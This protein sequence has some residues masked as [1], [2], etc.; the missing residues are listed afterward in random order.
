[1]SRRSFSTRSLSELQPD[2]PIINLADSTIVLQF[3]DCI[4]N[5]SISCR[6]SIWSQ[7]VSFH[8]SIQPQTRLHQHVDDILLYLVIIYGKE[9][10]PD[11]DDVV[12]ISK[13]KTFVASVPMIRLKQYLQHK[14]FPL[15]EHEFVDNNDYFARMIEDY[16]RSQLMYRGDISSVAS[17]TS[18]LPSL[19][20]I[21]GMSPDA[22]ALYTK[23]EDKMMDLFAS[24]FGELESRINHIEKEVYSIK[25]TLKNERTPTT[26]TRDISATVPDH[27]ME[28]IQ[29]IKEEMSKITK[30]NGKTKGSKKSTKNES[31]SKRKRAKTLSRVTVKQNTK[32]RDK[33]KKNDPK[34]IGKSKGKRSPKSPKSPKYTKEEMENKDAFKM[35][36]RNECELSQYLNLFMESALDNLSVVK[37]LQLSDLAL[38]GIKSN[39]DKIKIMQKIQKL[40]YEATCAPNRA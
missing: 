38:L 30:R 11:E 5:L 16:A 6:Q 25:N 31:Q 17:E 36:L 18:T 14:C 8:G 19:P 37:Y 39:A 22:T 1:M 20:S 35:W 23:L 2:E 40:K 27:I 3:A 10:Y 24:K 9:R 29:G 15:I 34:K 7:N 13:L 26:K 21:H 12:L 33:K 28:E 32:K 4:R